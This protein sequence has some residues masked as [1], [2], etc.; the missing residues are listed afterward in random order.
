VKVEFDS[1]AVS[2]AAITET[3]ASRTDRSGAHVLDGESEAVGV[4]IGDLERK[5]ICEGLDVDRSRPKCA[6]GFVR[7]NRIGELQ[8]RA[9]QFGVSVELHSSRGEA[10]AK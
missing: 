3:A 8:A 9:I 4:R 2:D 5:F 6:C 7:R 1:D 10:A